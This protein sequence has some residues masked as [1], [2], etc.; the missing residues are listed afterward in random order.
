ML[1]ILS[2]SSSVHSHTP[3]FSSSASSSSGIVFIVSLL[4]GFLPFHRLQF[5]S[6]LPQYSW[7][8]HLSDQPNNFL[9]IN[10]PSNSPCWNI[11]SLRSCY[12]TSSM[13][14]RYSFSNSLIASCVFFKFSLSSQVSDSIVNPF[15]CTKYLSF[16]LTRCLFRILFTS[17]SS[18]P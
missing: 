4:A 15:Q 8:Y 1:P 18:S 2:L 9:T 17:H 7:L 13:S 12:A 6:N 16:P 14:L 3:N 11:P 5:L 10:L